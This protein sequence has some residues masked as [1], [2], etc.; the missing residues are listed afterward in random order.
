MHT[1]KAINMRRKIWSTYSL[2]RLTLVEN[3]CGASG[4]GSSRG[5]CPGEFG[6]AELRCST[7]VICLLREVP[8]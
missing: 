5:L 3:G 1:N 4:A 2:L 7:G 6:V 8:D